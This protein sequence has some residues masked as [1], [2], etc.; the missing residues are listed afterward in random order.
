[1][2]LGRRSADMQSIVDAG[3]W[4]KSIEWPS[5]FDGHPNAF[6]RSLLLLAMGCCAAR[7]L[8]QRVE[9]LGLGESRR[10]PP[11]FRQLISSAPP[12]GLP[13]N[14]HVVP[15]CVRCLQAIDFFRRLILTVAK[16]ELLTDSH[17]PREYPSLPF[18]LSL[19]KLCCLRGTFL[20][21]RTQS[22]A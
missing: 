4:Y 10:S 16:L 18:E 19:R 21:G 22:P 8:G 1:M 6:R 9:L 7:D 12:L 17:C 20:G 13:Y 5:H 3:G 14:N 15:D 11:A 2:T